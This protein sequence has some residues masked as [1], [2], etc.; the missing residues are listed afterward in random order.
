MNKIFYSTEFIKQIKKYNKDLQTQI[1]KKLKQLETN[2]E[3]GK[4]LS[5]VLKN[6][7]SLHIGKYRVLYSIKGEEIII[8]K[9]DHRKDVYE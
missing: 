4:P 7:R 9:I 1:V 3:L 2:P 5:N 6:N 8:A